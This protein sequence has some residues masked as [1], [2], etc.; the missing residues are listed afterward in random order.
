MRHL[1]S[2]RELLNQNRELIFQS[3]NKWQI[4][5]SK[6]KSFSLINKLTPQNRSSDSWRPDNPWRPETYEQ[7]LSKSGSTIKINNICCKETILLLKNINTHVLKVVMHH[8]RSQLLKHKYSEDLNTGHLKSWPIQKLTFWCRKF[9]RLY[10][11][12]TRLLK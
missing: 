3:P 2:I 1:S 10:N 5:N 7:V 11:L 6:S 8:E 9:E 4:N 12:N